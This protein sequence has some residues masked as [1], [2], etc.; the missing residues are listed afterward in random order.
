MSNTTAFAVLLY[1]TKQV[2]VW[3]SDTLFT[4]IVKSLQVIQV[5]YE[6]TT[7]V[8][9]VVS[10]TCAKRCALLCIYRDQYSALFATTMQM[11]KAGLR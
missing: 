11:F 9:I 5:K 8:I 3:V 2:Y 7:L 1:M 4:K 6:P 10:G